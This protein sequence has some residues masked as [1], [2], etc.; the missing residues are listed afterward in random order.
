MVLPH[1]VYTSVQMLEKSSK[2]CNSLQ[3]LGGA[4]GVPSGRQSKLSMSLQQHEIVLEACPP[5]RPR[6]PVAG[7]PE[8]CNIE[9][10]LFFSISGL[11]AW[12]VYRGAWTEEEDVRTN[13]KTRLASPMNRP[14]GRCRIEREV[15]S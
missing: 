8:N 1:A 5:R 2:N 10:R 13:H 7:V 9:F 15:V 4:F 11:G 12:T 14:L 3:L 6:S